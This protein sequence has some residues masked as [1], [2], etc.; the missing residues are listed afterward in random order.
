MQQHRLFRSIVVCLVFVAPAAASAADVLQEVPNDALGFIVVHNLGAVDAKLKVLSSELRNTSFSPLDFLKTAAGVHDG[1]ESNGDFLLAVYKEGNAD[2]AELQFGVWLPVTDYERFAKSIG[3][4]STAGVAAATVAGQDLL[5]I[6]RGDWA[7]VMDPDQK[8]RIAQLAVNQ[9]SAPPEIAPWKTWIAS[10][11]VTVVAFAPG[12]H[13]LWSRL[14]ERFE[15]SKNGNGSS[16]DLFGATDNGSSRDGL[17]GNAM[18]HP[19]PTGFAGILSEI[20]KWAVAAPVIEQS[21]QQ[22]SL[23]GCGFRF[24]VEGNEHGNVQAKFRVSFDVP[25]NQESN[26]ENDLPYSLLEGDQFVIHGA[27][28]LPKSA[29][30][31]IATAYAQRLVDDIKSEEHTMLDEESAKQFAEAVALAAGD[32]RSAILLTQPGEQRLPVYSNDFVAVRVAS[33]DKFLAHAAEVMRL[34]N[35]ANREAQGEVRLVF[36]AE[37]A[38]F[39]NRSA[40]QYALDMVAIAGDPVVPETRQMMEKLFGP[41]GKLRLWFVRAD[42]RTVLLA[43]G[44]DEQVTAALKN[45]DR[46]KSVDFNQGQ[47]KNINALLSSEATLRVFFDPHR[48]NVWQRQESAAMIGVPVIGGPLVK[49]LRG[50]API[51]VAGSIRERELSVEVAALEPTLKSIYDHYAP[52]PKRPEVQRGLQATPR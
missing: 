40:T 25:F 44:T 26:G 18:N 43:R 6:H 12:I 24:N 29:F 31:G 14:E 33:A 19:S 49:S 32:V 2:D 8:Q 36:E 41:G 11:D 27:C 42:D 34:W 35:K 1:L 48:Y 5:I 37:E 17:V 39:G 22:A 9:P 50:C 13:E 47:L 45:F 4:T 15:N 7:I 46:K 38:K 21:L 30:V 10:N 16:D 3:A 52:T 23:A 51:G 20:H 28:R